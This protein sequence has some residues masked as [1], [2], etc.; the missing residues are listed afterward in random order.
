MAEK[1]KATSSK[2]REHG[3]P[4]IVSKELRDYDGMSTAK[5]AEEARRIGSIDGKNRA[6]LIFMIMKGE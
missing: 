1:K 2:F 3:S 5:L 6:Q 4:I